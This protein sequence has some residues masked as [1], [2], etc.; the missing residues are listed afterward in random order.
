[1]YV[2]GRQLHILTF[3]KTT[4]AQI[5]LVLDRVVKEVHA[6][7][8]DLHPILFTPPL[9]KNEK[10]RPITMMYLRIPCT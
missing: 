7:L 1:M 10:L 2:I 6:L 5:N 8:V 9:E 4:Y 3:R